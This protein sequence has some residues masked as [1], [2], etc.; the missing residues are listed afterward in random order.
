MDSEAQLV[1]LSLKQIYKPILE[2][3][4]L[5]FFFLDRILICGIINT[6]F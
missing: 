6:R 2:L 4:M 1:D 5:S 3:Y